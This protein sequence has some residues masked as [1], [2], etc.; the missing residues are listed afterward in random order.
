MGV[1]LKVSWLDM[2]KAFFLGPK[3]FAEMI[4]TRI[5]P[6]PVVDEKGH[7]LSPFRLIV[8]VFPRENPIPANHLHAQC[9]L[10]TGCSQGNIVSLEF[11]RRLG[12]K[13]EHF[14]ELNPEE[15]A[16][17]ISALGNAVVPMGAIRLSWYHSESSKV[18]TAMRFF[19]LEH[20]EVDL[21][22]GV[23]SIL[24][25]NLILPPNF[26]IDAPK[27]GRHGINHVSPGAPPKAEINE[28]RGRYKERIKKLQDQRT[29][30][31]DP[32][33]EAQIEKENTKLRIADEELKLIS[34]EMN[35]KA[36]PTNKDLINAVAAIKKDIAKLKKGL[37]KKGTENAKSESKDKS[38]PKDKTES[39]EKTEQVSE[40]GEKGLEIHL[41]DANGKVH[42]VKL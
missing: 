30:K 5:V 35:Q 19:V 36:H 41:N 20:T 17:G 1:K 4:A 2:V 24:Q 12:Y 14:E 21:L 10:D 3:K 6:V 33:L 26:K 11:A 16:A 40:I 28:K 37:G 34:A 9:T 29:D 42:E 31:V 38:D 25:F 8:S 39:K 32:K 7:K 18:F 15:A 22:I 13:E 23:H 27:R